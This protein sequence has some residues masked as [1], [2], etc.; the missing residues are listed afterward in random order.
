MKRRELLKAILALPIISFLPI[1]NRKGEPPRERPALLLATLIAG[2]QYYGGEKIL[3]QLREGQPLRLIRERRNRHDE[4]AI[5]IYRKEHKLGYIPRADNS[6]LANLMDEGYT[7]KAEIGWLDRD[8]APWEKVGV[9]IG[10][11]SV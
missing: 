2:F 1:L 6:V 11:K 9:L 5:A 8:A 4:R 7:L 3:P 10:T